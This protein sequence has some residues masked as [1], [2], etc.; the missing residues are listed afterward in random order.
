MS[1]IT[2]LETI[3]SQRCGNCGMLFGMEENYREEL[4]NRGGS[5]WCPKGCQR[6]FIDETAK[7]KAKR[8]EEEAEMLKR[9]LAQANSDNNTFRNEAFKQREKRL[10]LE[11]RIK[12]GVCPHCTRS[13]QNLKN[14]IATM[15][16]N[17]KEKK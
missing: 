2:V 5:F 15:H 10:K 1:T 17:C 14:H 11:K 3:V 9:R 13:F 12:N 4:V 16:S 8:L 6:K 7:A